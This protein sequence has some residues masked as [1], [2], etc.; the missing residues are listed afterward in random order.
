MFWVIFWDG[1]ALCFES[2]VCN[3][4]LY[5]Q[6]R[7]INHISLKKG[8]MRSYFESNW[9]WN[10]NLSSSLFLTVPRDF[11]AFLSFCFCS[12]LHPM[13]QEMLLRT[14][15]PLSA[16]WEVVNIHSFHPLL[17]L[18]RSFMVQFRE[19]VWLHK[20]ESLGLLQTLM[21]LWS[22]VHWNN[23]I[24]RD[25]VMWDSFFNTN[26]FSFK[27]GLECSKEWSEVIQSSAHG[28]LV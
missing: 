13:W 6:K 20:L 12:R 21:K 19:R 18:H 17:L 7:S 14:P 10:I 2:S 3:T 15:N 1:F 9:R 24:A 23:A 28:S 26:Q 25:N 27:K 16:F 8:R 5:V 11:A 4:E 22:D